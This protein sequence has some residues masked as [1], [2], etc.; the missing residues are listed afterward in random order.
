MKLLYSKINT[1]VD[2]L[3]YVYEFYIG[4]NLSNSSV[5]PF[6][7]PPAVSLIRRY[8]NSNKTIYINNNN[9]NNKEMSHIFY[10][11]FFL[12]TSLHCQPKLS[13]MP[14]S[15]QLS[16]A[17]AETAR[18][19]PASWRGPCGDPDCEALCWEAVHCS[20]G[21]HRPPVTTTDLLAEDD[22]LGTL[23]VCSLYFCI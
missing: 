1:L 19:E 11:L 12:P 4:Q 18:E 21:T 22:E 13:D 15:S 10:F 23:R 6:P 17:V 3:W 9:N 5:H 2:I 14:S 20:W 7:T 8:Q 16:P